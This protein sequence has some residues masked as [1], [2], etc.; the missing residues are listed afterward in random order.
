MRLEM[1]ER[2]IPTKLAEEVNWGMKDW[3]MNGK[4][5]IITIILELFR[6]SEASGTSMEYLL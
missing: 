2:L 5:P 6:Q 4:E 3:G 1:M